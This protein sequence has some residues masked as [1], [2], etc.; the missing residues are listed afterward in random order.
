MASRNNVSQPADLLAEMEDESV[1][2]GSDPFA[3]QEEVPSD[4]AELF[5]DMLNNEPDPEDIARRR[6]SLYLPGGPYRWL[7]MIDGTP[8]TVL[9]S[10]KSDDKHPNDTAQQKG[11]DLGRMV[12][13]VSGIVQGTKV[14]KNRGRFQFQCSP[15]TRTLDDGK[16]DFL[17]QNWNKAME[18][19]FQLKERNPSNL[20]VLNMLRSGRYVMYI[21][22]SKKN[23]Q[24]YL[25][26]FQRIQ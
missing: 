15:D 13:A 4:L 6:A 9:T 12:I 26:N 22:Q 18:F 19:T 24:N 7:P 5:N 25:G 21:T 2:M 1:N 20:E 23:G 3:G 8:C 11:R 17:T 16:D 10:F 14:D